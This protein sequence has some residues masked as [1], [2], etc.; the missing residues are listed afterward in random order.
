[1]RRRSDVA[2]RLTSD[3]RSGLAALYS[4]PAELRAIAGECGLR[5]LRAD[6]WMPVR[7]IRC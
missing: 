5:N 7:L 4:A 1:M 2:L 3:F 6:Y